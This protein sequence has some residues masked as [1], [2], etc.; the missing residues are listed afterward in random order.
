MLYVYWTCAVVGGT[1][2]VCQFLLALLG[3]GHHSFDTS[4]GHDVHS[5]DAHHGGHAT[6]LSAV[7]AVRTV[8]ATVAFFGV[9]GMAAR[10]KGIEP[11]RTLCI[12]LLGGAIGLAAGT[13]L[14]RIL[15]RMDQEGNAYIVHAI[16]RTGRVYLTVPGHGAGAGKVQV[17]VQDRTME[18]LAVT[19]GEEVM[20]G[21][22]VLVVEAIGHDTVEV[23]AA[24]ENEMAPQT[25]EVRH[26]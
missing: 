5:G 2:I 26:V 14:T 4:V 22:R 24:S 10:A 17:C 7:L 3:M 9:A 1:L 20:T 19:R 11:P 25:N 6:W 13:W 15:T 21:A 18:Y 23:V 8:I 12:A 16:G